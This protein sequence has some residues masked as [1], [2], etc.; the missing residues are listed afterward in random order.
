MRFCS[1]LFLII[2]FDNRETFTIGRKNNQY[3]MKCCYQ[4]ENSLKL[5][6]G[7]YIFILVGWFRLVRMGQVL[8]STSLWILFW[9]SCEYVPRGLKE[10]LIEK[11][12]KEVKISGEVIFFLGQNWRV[13]LPSPPQLVIV[14]K[15]PW[16]Y[17]KLHVKREPYLF[18]N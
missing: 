6:L 2:F 18:S 15:L 17:E 4:I 10:Y 5:T 16:T 8:K 14:L 13:V 1:L 9:L 12:L 11:V 7:R 3:L